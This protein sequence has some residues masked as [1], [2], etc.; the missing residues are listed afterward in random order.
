[1]NL[2]RFVVPGAVV[3]ALSACGS[4]SSPTPKSLPLT[5]IPGLASCRPGDHPL[6]FVTPSKLTGPAA[7]TV[8][9]WRVTKGWSA[10]S[11]A[12]RV[13]PAAHGSTP[14]VP[15][16]QAACNL[17]AA[18]NPIGYELSGIAQGGST[19]G[20]GRLSISPKL[21]SGT[22]NLGNNMVITHP[23]VFTNRPAWILT[24]TVVTASAAC[25]PQRRPG[26][27]PGPALSTPPPGQAP[28]VQYGVFALDAEKGR[29]S[30]TFI[31][32]GYELCGGA[33]TGYA[34]VPY[35][36]VSVPWRLGSISADRRSGQIHVFAPACDTIPSD[37]WVRANGTT[38]VRA[39]VERPVGTPCGPAVWRT[40]SLHPATYRVPIPPQ[41]THAALGA[42]DD[43]TLASGG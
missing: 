20:Y 12:L 9:G 39:L 35:E 2:R 36:V 27:S 16:L 32:S 3:I 17:L 28:G 37:T 15:I 31:G 33:T 43:P 23:P 24:T 5:D 7:G 26:T 4:S 10:D 34:A 38:E 6:R 29:E 41:L 25:P 14:T 42:M 18:T 11:G 8:T 30:I 21:R 13:S 40:M 22:A 1:V 19:F